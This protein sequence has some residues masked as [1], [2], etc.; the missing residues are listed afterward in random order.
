MASG[1]LASLAFAGLGF[2]AWYLSSWAG[3][4]HKQRWGFQACRQ[5]LRYRG[6][7]VIRIGKQRLGVW[8]RRAS[9]ASAMGRAKPASLR[10]SVTSIAT[11]KPCSAVT[12]TARY[13]RPDR[14]VREAHPARLRIGGG[15]RRF[16]LLAF[17][18]GCV[19]LRASCSALS[20]SSAFCAAS[21]F[22]RRSRAA[23]SSA[24]WLRQAG[25][26]GIGLNLGLQCLN[27]VLGGLVSFVQRACRK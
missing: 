11:I 25:G 6:G 12:A 22:L 15:R 16:F 10:R 27:P 2:Q 20:F 3:A 23:R 5:A 1:S 17:V 18:L 24:A 13:S 26:G 19:F 9:T 14:A 8:P 21:T 7:C 4:A